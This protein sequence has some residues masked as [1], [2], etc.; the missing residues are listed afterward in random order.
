VSKSLN[1]Q[2]VKQARALIEDE[3]RWCRSVLA[4]DGSGLSVCPTGRE[5]ERRCA[6]GALIAAAYQITNDHDRARDI[7]IRAL[8]PWY[9]TATL[10]NVND[11]RGHDA[12]LALFD[13]VIAMH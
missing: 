3:R 12:V 8:R 1:A 6:L 5:A 4:R 11:L 9:G 7:A 10:V 13:E 2:V